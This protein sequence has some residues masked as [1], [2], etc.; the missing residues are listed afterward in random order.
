MVHLGNFRPDTQVELYS[1]SSRVVFLYYQLFSLYL[2]LNKFTFLL[3]GLVWLC[4]KSNCMQRLRLALY[5]ILAQIGWHHFMYEYDRTV[6][7]ASF[8]YVKV[9]AKPFFSHQNTNIFVFDMPAI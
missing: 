7:Q 5:T 8:D 4:A 9:S 2:Y 1:K 3:K 6:Y